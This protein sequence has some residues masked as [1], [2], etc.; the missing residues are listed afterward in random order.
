MS[1]YDVNR[2]Q[3]PEDDEPEDA[4][5]VPNPCP[6]E[7]PLPLD[8][9]PFVEVRF[10]LSAA[11]FGLL[12]RLTHR[13]A[14]GEDR[15]ATRGEIRGEGVP[16]S[17][18]RPREDARPV[19]RPVQGLPGRRGDVQRHKLLVPPQ[20]HHIRG[21]GRRHRLRARDARSRST[22]NLPK[23]MLFGSSVAGFR[24]VKRW[25]M[26]TLC[27]SRRGP[28]RPRRR[29]RHHAARVH[30]RPARAR[31]PRQVGP[32]AALERHEDERP[33]SG[34]SLALPLMALWAC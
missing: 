22:R 2:K 21:G 27:I 3:A 28:A 34:G 15:W 7:I 31:A 29:A 32:L 10:G 23:C 18:A 16:A 14:G 19:L 6:D 17:D 11:R 25:R 13:T 4:P 20:R 24:A 30:P 1:C 9:L 8:Q 33:G 12:Y 5:C 26:V